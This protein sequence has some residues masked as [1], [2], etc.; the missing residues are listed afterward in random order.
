MSSRTCHLSGLPLGEN[1]E[2]FIIPVEYSHLKETSSLC[3]ATN[4]NCQ[5]FWL[6]MKGV[7]GEYGEIDKVSNTNTLDLLLD[8]VNSGLLNNNKFLNENNRMF[9]GTNYA[10]IEREKYTDDFASLE[11]LSDLEIDHLLLSKKRLHKIQKIDSGIKLLDLLSSNYLCSR[12]KLGVK[13]YSLITI[14]LSIFNKL[15]KEHYSDL[16][17]EIKSDVFSF[18]EKGRFSSFDSFGRNV[19]QLRNNAESFNY[20]L[21]EILE[22]LATQKNKD[23]SLTHKLST[24]N[25]FVNSIVDLALISR[26][27]SDT[28]KSFYPNIRNTKGMKPIYNLNNIVNDEIDETRKNNREKWSV[29]NGYSED[30]ADKQEWCDY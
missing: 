15:V 9:Y 23:G 8:N 25:D 28:S 30:E 29:E 4:T 7:L 22:T 16:K 12:E 27:Y 13:R 1:S 24:L 5:P 19:L 18:L 11:Y 21:F 17:N 2:V 14:K 6:S 26:I 10:L 3:Y 20:D